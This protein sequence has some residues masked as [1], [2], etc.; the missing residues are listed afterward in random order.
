MYSGGPLHMAEQRQGDQ[1]KH[2]YGSSVRIRDAALRTYRKRWTIGR[3]VREGQGHDDD[4]DIHPAKNL[5]TP[6]HLYGPLWEDLY[7]GY[8]IEQLIFMFHKICV[9]FV[10]VVNK[11][12]KAIDW[13]GSGFK[14]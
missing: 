8:H 4:D 11:V 13:M 5:L 10:R 14:L 7:L 2:T 9:L 1:L 12:K 6:R 3:V